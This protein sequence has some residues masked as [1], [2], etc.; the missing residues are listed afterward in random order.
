[1]W[2][3]RHACQRLSI[4]SQLLGKAHTSLWMRL[5]LF[6]FFFLAILVLKPG[7]K[8]KP[9]VVEAWSLNLWTA[10]EIPRLILH[11]LPVSWGAGLDASRMA[12]D[13]VLRCYFVLTFR[14]GMDAYQLSLWAVLT[15][16][17][18]YGGSQSGSFSLEM[19]KSFA[20]P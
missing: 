18:C 19:P 5:I 15:T 6:F 11:A 9:P 20:G 12:L 16:L 13:I 1:M 7:I 2:T 3:L 4:P 8:P 17:S 14:R 10:R